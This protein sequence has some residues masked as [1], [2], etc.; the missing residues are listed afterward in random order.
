M[1]AATIK[2]RFHNLGSRPTEPAAATAS[3]PDAT[4]PTRAPSREGK[5]V[6]T[7]YVRP[8]TWRELHNIALDEGTSI[9]GLMHQAL[10][11]LARSR[12]LHPFAEGTKA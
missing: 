5:K 1:S 4:K 9:Q 8:Q 3:R 10:D 12:S 11:L 6:V 2:G 7:F